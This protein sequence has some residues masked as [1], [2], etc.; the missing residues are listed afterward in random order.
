MKPR[1]ANTRSKLLCPDCREVRRVSTITD[2]VLLLVCGHS[3][4]E[5]L[6]LHAGHISLEQIRTDK[7]QRFFP[8]TK[9][10]AQATQVGAIH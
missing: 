10:D 3:R 5:L 8:L 9:D 6:P 1:G 2:G 4:G 7:G